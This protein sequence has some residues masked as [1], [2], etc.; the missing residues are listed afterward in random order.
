MLN[1]VDL[2]WSGASDNVG[3]DHY[4]A[5]DG[6][7]FLKRLDRETRTYATPPLSVGQHKLRVVAYDA[8][9]NYANSNEVEVTILAGGNGAVQSVAATTATQT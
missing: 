5:W 8:A 7:T 6:A 1:R 3:I 4:E 9:G 2:Q